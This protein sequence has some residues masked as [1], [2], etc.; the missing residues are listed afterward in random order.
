MNTRLRLAASFT[1]VFSA[2][3]ISADPVQGAVPAPPASSSPAIIRDCEDCPDLL[4]IPKG[5]FM[6]GTLPGGY[7]QTEATGEG[8]PVKIV[9][10]APF[11]IGRNEITVRQ[12]ATFVKATKYRP[13]ISCRVFQDGRW[14]I[15]S[16]ASWARSPSGEALRDD[17]P[18]TCVSWQDTR[19]YVAWLSA[20]SGQHYRLPSESEW[21]YASRGGVDAPR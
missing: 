6:M 4:L 3:P 2:I 15:A 20:R 13:A 11:L 5:T 1:V 10:P 18:V 8:E 14:T 17:W 12:F 16:K 21:D 19:T 9:V 7:E